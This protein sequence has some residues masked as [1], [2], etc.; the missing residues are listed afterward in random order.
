MPNH[1]RHR[2]TAFK[3]FIFRYEYRVDRFRPWLE[4]DTGTY[5]FRAIQINGITQPVGY[6]TISG[7]TGKKWNRYKIR[8]KH[9]LPHPAGYYFYF[10]ST[11]AFSGRIPVKI[12]P[13]WLLTNYVQV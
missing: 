2:E 11:T 10:K 9:F 7:A 8:P 4:H 13:N 6:V 3:H 12:Y 1:S 5:L